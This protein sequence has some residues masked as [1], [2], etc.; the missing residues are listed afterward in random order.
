MAT[1]EEVRVTPVATWGQKIKHLLHILISFSHRCGKSLANSSLLT[2]AQSII[3][4]YFLQTDH[5]MTIFL[6]HRYVQ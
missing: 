2:L 4:T 3:T 5:V 6:T 1:E